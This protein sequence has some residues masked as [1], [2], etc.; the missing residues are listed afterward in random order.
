M[1]KRLCELINIFQTRPFRRAIKWAEL[2]AQEFAC[3]GDLERQLGMPVQP[4]N[5]R[6][7]MVLEDM[8]IGFIRFVAM[9]LFQSVA[10]VTHGM[11]N[12]KDTC[13][14]IIITRVWIEISF[15]VETMEENLNRWEDRKH[16]QQQQVVEEKDSV[17]AEA[18]G[19]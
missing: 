13:I 4:M 14:C 2:L 15:T 16:N 9:N 6:D 19:K 7:K 11:Y 1:R 12:D 10:D 17:M 8:Q 5:D 3:Q 18:T